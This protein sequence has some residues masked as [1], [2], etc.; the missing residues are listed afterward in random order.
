M[1]YSNWIFPGMLFLAFA[2]AQA[3]STQAIQSDDLRAQVLSLRTQVDS[4]RTEIYQRLNQDEMAELEERFEKQLRTLESKID[5]LARSTASTIFNPRTTAFLNFAA[6]KDGKQVT[7]EEGSMAIDNRLFLRSI[8]LDFR[9]AVDPYAEAVVIFS[10][11]DEAGTGFAFEPEEAYA[12]IKR[13]PVFETA[14]LGMKVKVGKFRVPFG[15]SNRLHMHDLPWTTRPLIISKYLGTEHGDFFESGF[16]PVGL[17]FDLFLPSPVPGATME[18]NLSFVR[19]GDLRIARP[20]PD[21]TVLAGKQ[22]ALAAHVTL[23]SDWNNE[24]LLAGGFSSYFER[25]MHY[26]HASNLVERTDGKTNLFGVDLTYKWTPARGG[27]SRSFVVGG[28]V[29]FGTETSR[30]G[31]GVPETRSPFGWYTYAQY[32]FSFGTYLGVRYD[33]VREPEDLNEVTQAIG[34][35]LSYYTT[36]F[37]RFRIGVDRRAS[38][39]PSVNGRTG[40]LFEVNVVFGSHPT[41]PYWVTR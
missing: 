4:L 10:M 30:D 12:L 14:P 38:S 29:I 35:Y 31:E 16:N 17:D 26:S 18:M 39:S 3:Q 41:E 20:A 22:P 36:E 2:A 40:V 24:H 13:L 27:S 15:V 37:L 33:R 21:Y 1:V 19:A 6:R 8:E 9:G 23:S 5:G 25:G 11:E 32:Q 7:D 28:E 34:V